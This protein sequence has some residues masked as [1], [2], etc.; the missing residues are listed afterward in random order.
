M[1]HHMNQHL[2]AAAFDPV[3]RLEAKLEALNARIARLSI[4]LGMPLAKPEDMKRIL[5]LDPSVFP[6]HV[7]DRSAALQSDSEH[8]QAH[9]WQ[10]LR[11]LIVLRYEL[12]AQAVDEFGPDLTGRIAVMVEESLELGGFAPGADGFDLTP[13]DPR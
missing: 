7:T 6:A 13:L 5:A 12:I 9:E 8:R 1:N 10:E 4:L 11:G 2:D 3:S